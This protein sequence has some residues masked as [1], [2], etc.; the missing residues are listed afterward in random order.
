MPQPARSRA[1]RT[2]ART[3]TRGGSALSCVLLRVGRCHSCA[4]PL[5]AQSLLKPVHALLE[6][7]TFRRRESWR[8]GA[9]T[10]RRRGRQPLPFGAALQVF[11]GLPCT[12]DEL[13]IICGAHGPRVGG[14]VARRLPGGLVVAAQAEWLQGTELFQ[15]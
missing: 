11:P 14:R 1:A 4:S 9:S 12:R 15:E 6:R 7:L 10:G 3:R 8:D 5:E 13:R 2:A